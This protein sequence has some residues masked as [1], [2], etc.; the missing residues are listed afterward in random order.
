MKQ[1][2]RR[3]SEFWQNSAGKAKSEN[4]DFKTRVGVDNDVC[5]KQNSR[6]ISEF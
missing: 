3:I 5:M 4:F 1:N 6:R 2:S